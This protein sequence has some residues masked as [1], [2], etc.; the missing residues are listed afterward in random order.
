M[1]NV[2]VVIRAH[3]TKSILFYFYA[4]DI[5]DAHIVIIVFK[6]RFVS[7]SSSGSDNNIV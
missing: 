4:L 7:H 2:T 6:M 1:F 3:I 5:T